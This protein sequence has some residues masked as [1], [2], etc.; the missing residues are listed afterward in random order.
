MER[1][2]AQPSSGQGSGNRRGIIVVCSVRGLLGV[3]RVEVEDVICDPLRFGRCAEYLAAV[4]LKD[5]NPGLNVTRVIGNVAGQSDHGAD[6]AGSQLSSQFLLRV[7]H[8]AE[9]AAQIT[10]QS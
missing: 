7:G 2:G 5:T 1:G 8:G 10:V 4:L 6:R 9:L 3:V